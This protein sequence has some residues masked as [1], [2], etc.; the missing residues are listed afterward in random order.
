MS[1]ESIFLD[2]TSVVL[3]PRST[4]DSLERL[5][6]KTT[7]DSALYED[8]LQEALVHLWL[9]ERRRPGQTTS[10]YLQSCKFHLQH[11][12]ASGRSVDSTKR[13]SGQLQFA[14]DSEEE[15]GI[16]EQGDEGNS[17]VTS[18]SARELMSLLSP[19]LSA[20]ENA[21]L[22]CLADGLGARAIGRELNMSH[23]MVIKHRRRIAALLE[24]LDGTTFSARV[25]YNR[26]PEPAAGRASLDAPSFRAAEIDCEE[27]A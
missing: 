3:D 21:V 13:R 6:R 1:S 11:Y 10:W 25:A 26:R 16:P 12:L 27:A 4:K 2:M 14:Q 7:T 24:R 17:V 15:D 5:I 23:T 8:L 18:V 9:T 19:L 22:D 20:Q